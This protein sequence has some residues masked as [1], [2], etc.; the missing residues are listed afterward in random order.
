MMGDADVGQPVMEQ[1]PI[2]GEL[3][4]DNRNDPGR[5]NNAP[6]NAPLVLG[7]VSRFR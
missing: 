5:Q 4:F 6:Y 3:L 2:V 7:I 1:T